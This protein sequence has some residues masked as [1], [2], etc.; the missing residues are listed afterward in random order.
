MSTNNDTT[1]TSTCANCGKSEECAGD[2]K[3][4]TAC[5]M[6]KYCNRDCQ[7]AH[8]PQH[9][10]EC[11]KRA[12]ELHDIELFKQPPPNEDCP[13]CM[14]PL[15]EL[16]TGSKYKV[17]CGKDI[18]SGCI[19]AVAIRDGGVGLCP[20]CRTPAST[21]D[22]EI[23]KRTKKRVE[24]DDAVAIYIMG[25]HYNKGSRGLPQNRA[26]ALE[27]WN[28]A[29][30]LGVAEAYFNI[31]CA[32]D[33]GDGAAERDEKKAVHYYELAAMG[34]DIEARHNLGCSERDAGNYDRALK[35]FMIS[36]GG[37][38]KESLSAIQEMFKR[39]RATKEDYMD[40]LRAYQ[41][42]LGEIKSVQRNEA[43]AFS[44]DYY[45]YY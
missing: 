14:L 6:V 31:G 9:K 2:L 36:A 5:K 38:E 19:H 13:I 35:H 17:C 29:A 28:R 18:C 10:R 12:A 20:F 3:A 34:G 43:A 39:G 22:E 33:Y 40:A 45:K 4:C 26:N 30:E 16:E 44:E 8:R 25:C 7:V 41:A 23:I 32:Y 21:S 37:G 24:V 42:F 11:K 1:S 27:L 15:P